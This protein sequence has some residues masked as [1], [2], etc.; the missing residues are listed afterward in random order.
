[1]AVPIPWPSMTSNHKYNKNLT[2]RGRPR[3]R[4]SVAKR[5]PLRGVLVSR[6]RGRLC[7]RN[8]EH[9]NYFNFSLQW[10]AERS[11]NLAEL[12]RFLIKL[13]SKKDWSLDFEGRAVSFVMMVLT[14]LVS[15][16]T[17]SLGC[18][19][20]VRSDTEAKELCAVLASRVLQLEFQYREEATNILL[21]RC[22][23][24]DRNRRARRRLIMPRPMKSIVPSANLLSSDLMPLYMEEE[25]YG[26]CKLIG[27]EK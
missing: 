18:Q 26:V 11:K 13:K 1:M 2:L 25:S 27:Y 16:G 4:G 19:M 12:S 10:S 14:P 20:F 3:H 5:R 7:G 23:P 15:G 9:V 21:L 22:L 24:Y 6:P 8:K 17:R